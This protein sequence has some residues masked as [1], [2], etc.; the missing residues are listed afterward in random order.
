MLH[1]KCAALLVKQIRTLFR[2]SRQA[3]SQLVFC[4]LYLTQLES[5][6][7]ACTAGTKYLH[8]RCVQECKYA[9]FTCCHKVSLVFGVL[10]ALE[11]PGGESQGGGMAL[12]E[13]CSNHGPNVDHGALRA[14]RQ[15]A[16]HC[17]RTGDKFDP[18]RAY[19]EYL[20]SNCT[21]YISKNRCREVPAT[22][23]IYFDE[24]EELFR[25]M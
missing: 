8:C 14:D 7:M 16:A 9:M 24:E 25:T 20:A 15:P 11:E 3:R 19:I 1:E 23:A 18:Q 12:A 5:C 22:Q 21:W 4:T 13:G 10:E 17:C 2:P 6:K